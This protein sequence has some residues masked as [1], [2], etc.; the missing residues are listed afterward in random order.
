MQSL[1]RILGYI[2]GSTSKIF[3][4]CL[5]SFLNIL[6]DALP[7]VILGFAID[8][9][10]N[11]QHS[12]LSTLGIQNSYKQLLTLGAISILIYGLESLF[13]Y[14]YSITWKDLAQLIQH[15]LRIDTYQHIQLLDTQYFEEKSSGL[16]L[17]I[18][19]DDINLLEQFFNNDV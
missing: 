19:V 15:K 11:R 8:S 14:L 5:Y 1:F 10:V 9:V 3:L 4:A 2:Q 6:F 13:E 12:Y 7:E 18:L 17:N 16:L